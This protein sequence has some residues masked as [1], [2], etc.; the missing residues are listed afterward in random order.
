VIQAD[1]GENRITF[2]GIEIV[3]YRGMIIDNVKL[4]RRRDNWSADQSFLQAI[5]GYLKKGRECPLC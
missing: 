2:E 3:H 5:Q 4:F 1:G